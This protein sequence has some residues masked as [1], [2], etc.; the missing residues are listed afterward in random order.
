MSVILA[1]ACCCDDD[2]NGSECE[3]NFD[4]FSC[5]TGLREFTPPGG[6]SSFMAPSLGLSASFL[7]VPSGPKIFSKST[8]NDFVAPSVVGGLV[9]NG[10]EGDEN[11]DY[12]GA[13]VGNW[14][15]SPSSSNYERDR[16]LIAYGEQ[17]PNNFVP[18]PIRVYSTSATPTEILSGE[19]DSILPDSLVQQL[20]RMELIILGPE[21]CKSEGCSLVSTMEIIYSFRNFNRPKLRFKFGFYRGTQRDGGLGPDC[22]P[23][24]ASGLCDQIPQD[25]SPV[26]MR[27]DRPIPY[28][29]GNECGVPQ[30][31]QEEIKKKDPTAFD[32]WYPMGDLCT[33]S[34]YYWGE[35]AGGWHRDGCEDTTD[36]IY[37]TRPSVSA[38]CSCCDFDFDSRELSAMVVT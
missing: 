13:K 16:L 37:G 10:L 7:R 8:I 27:H 26:V 5:A 9:N 12:I 15:A 1:A 11:F 19:A 33:G 6:G 20:D 36:K 35:C 24:G 28:V 17:W 18:I 21:Q 22:V 3:T 23:T 14:S 34:N 30:A 32:N 29:F 2:G 4:F 38:A 31:I 25:L